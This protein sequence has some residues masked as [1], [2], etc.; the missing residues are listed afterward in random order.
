MSVRLANEKLPTDC[1]VH[2]A[3]SLG[4]AYEDLKDYD[5]AFEHYELANQLHRDTIAYDP[6]QTEIAHER[7]RDIFSVDFF[8][9]KMADECLPPL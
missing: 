8:N 1:R 6:V 7:M 5:R 9:G 4:K 2:F 3:F